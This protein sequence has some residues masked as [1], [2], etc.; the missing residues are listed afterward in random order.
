M[1][2]FPGGGY[3]ELAIDFEG[4]EIC[5]WLTSRGIT[6][7]LLKYRVPTRGPDPYGE[8]LPA[9]QDAQRTMALVRTVYDEVHLA[10]WGL[11]IAFVIYFAVFVAPNLPELDAAAERLRLHAIADENEAYC[12]KWRMGPG[13]ATHTEC[14]M[15]LQALRVHI[16][17]QL[18]ADADF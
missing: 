17:R 4:T 5:D 1:L 15:D 16:E 6:A 12:A 11:L 8:S 10:L 13:T 2:V 7:V 3:K 18:E 9:L 14:L